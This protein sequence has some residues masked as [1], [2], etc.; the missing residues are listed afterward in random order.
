MI[1]FILFMACS[2]D[3]EKVEVTEEKAQTEQTQ[4][5][6]TGEGPSVKTETPVKQKTVETVDMEIVVEGPFEETKTDSE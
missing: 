2:D 6:T 3:T 1:S 4:T 5:T